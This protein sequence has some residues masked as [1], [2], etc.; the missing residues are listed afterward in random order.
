M[1]TE[2]PYVCKGVFMRYVETQFATKAGG[3]AQRSELRP[4][5]RMS[6]PG[7]GACG[8]IADS[9]LEFPDHLEFGPGITSGDVVVMGWKGDGVDWETG[10]EDYHLIANL[11]KEKT[12]DPH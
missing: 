3:W 11:H 8:C 7:C 2:K 6:C 12:H 4:L 5:K 1:D 9:L 10:H